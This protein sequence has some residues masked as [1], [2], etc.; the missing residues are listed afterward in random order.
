MALNIK[1]PV[2]E[3]LAAEVAALAGESKTRAVR[4]ALEE[5]RAR[6][7]LSG[8]AAEKSERIRRFLEEEVWP[9]IP[10]K[11]RGKRITKKERER[12]LGYGPHGV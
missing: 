4:V 8:A 7:S 2:A 9:T 6:L 10:K 3:R 11:F 5:R 12:I 1:D